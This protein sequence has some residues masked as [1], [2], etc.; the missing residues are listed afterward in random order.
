MRALVTGGSGFLG[1]Y[2]V[3]LLVNNGVQ[4]RT[5]NRNSSEA[6]ANI[7]VDQMLGDVAD[8]AITEVA[9]KGMDVVFHVASKVGYWGQYKDF[10]RANVDGTQ[11]VINSCLANGVERL[12]YTSSPSV[13]MNNRDIFNGDESLPYAD[14]YATHYSA[15]KAEAER[16]VLAANGQK[17]LIT[18][19]LRPHLIIGPRDNHLIPRLVTKAMQGSLVQIGPG[20]NK[21]SVCYVEN[22]AYAHWQAAHSDNVGGKAYF[23]NEPEPVILWQLINRLL[24]EVGIGAVKRKVP[25]K[26]AYGAGYILELV[27]TLIPSLGEPR[28]TRFLAAELYRNHYF[29]I[30][31]AQRDFDYQPPFT[32]AQA[33]QLTLAW[34]RDLVKTLNH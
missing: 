9:T 11:N 18:T 23:I 13:T 31:R 10:Y 32:L 26:V 3:E 28:V 27:H 33:E 6:L 5:L 22:A 15:T 21:V 24:D 17:G 2:L 4:V 25:F 29:N 16:R 8:P 1:R 12:I 19:S 34:M 20:E 7:Q 14:S 30:A